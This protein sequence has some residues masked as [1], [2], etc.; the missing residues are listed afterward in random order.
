MIRYN[1]HYMRKMKTYSAMAIC[2]FFLLSTDSVAQVATKTPQKSGPSKPS[3][4]LTRALDNV[5]TSMNAL[6]KGKRDTISLLVSGIEYDNTNLSTLRDDLKK[7]KGVKSVAFTY[8]DSS[9]TM[10]IGYKG[11]ATD[12][13]DN[14][15]PDIKGQ[16]KILEAGNQNLNL[17]YKDLK[18]TQ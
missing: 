9:A 12:L 13:W 10:K 7:L 14:L 16:F 5:K 4:S 11:N 6:F 2:L 18:P 17:K 3:D 8:K 1:T 15:P